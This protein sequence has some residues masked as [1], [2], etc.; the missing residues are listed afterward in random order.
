MPDLRQQVHSCHYEIQTR[1]MTIMYLSN[2]T[3]YMLMSVKQLGLPCKKIVD[4]PISICEWAMLSILPFVCL[5]A[6]FMFHTIHPKAAWF[7]KIHIKKTL[8]KVWFA[9]CYEVFWFSAMSLNVSISC[10]S[11]QVVFI[12][13]CSMHL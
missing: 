2:N 3:E 6:W 11:G 4:P 8:V 7:I 12:L 13:V 9:F 5:T 1:L 10:V